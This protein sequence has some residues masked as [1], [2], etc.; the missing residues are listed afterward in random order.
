MWGT[1][2]ME[3]IGQVAK[4][5]GVTVGTV[6]SWDRSG[7]IRSVRTPGGH[8]RYETMINPTSYKLY[9]IAND[10][11]LPMTEAERRTLDNVLA[12]GMDAESLAKNMILHMRTCKCSKL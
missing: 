3:T 2:L 7:K 12:S 1:Q 10:T 11:L 6:R 5:H 9:D 8:R 4:K